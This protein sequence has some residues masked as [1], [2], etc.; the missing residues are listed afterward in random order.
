MLSHASTSIGPLIGISS[1]VRLAASSFDSGKKGLPGS[2]WRKKSPDKTPH[3]GQVLAEYS[4]SMAFECFRL[5]EGNRFWT[6]PR[7]DIGNS[8]ML[9]RIQTSP[10]VS[11]TFGAMSPTAGIS[12]P[13][14]QQ[15]IIVQAR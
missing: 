3:L 9:E 1:T 12:A 13:H 2:E 8:V 7:T 4:D 14:R 5:N 11:G 10:P 6:K 15:E